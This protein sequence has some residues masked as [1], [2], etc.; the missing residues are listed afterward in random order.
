M[1]SPFITNDFPIAGKQ[2]AGLRTEIRGGITGYHSRNS[3]DRRE[4]N[5]HAQRAA[6][7]LSLEMAW[8]RR[9]RVTVRVAASSVSLVSRSVMAF[10]Q[11]AA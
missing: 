1:Q 10:S 5:R 7:C 9:S 4:L 2:G 8:S 3:G 6:A 11:R